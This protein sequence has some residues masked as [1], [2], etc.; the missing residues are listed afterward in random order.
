MGVMG[1]KQWERVFPAVT[2][3][4]GREP[5]RGSPTPTTGQGEFPFVEGPGFTPTGQRAS[6]PPTPLI[7]ELKAAR[8]RE[9]SRRG[10]I[11]SPLAALPAYLRPDSCGDRHSSESPNSIT[12]ALPMHSGDLT[13][14]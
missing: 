13:Q 8:S 11:V 5:Y 1:E 10:S 12:H 4:G 14:Q 6:L 3:A 9:L 2:T 7:D